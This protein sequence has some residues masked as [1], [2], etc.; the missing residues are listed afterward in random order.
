MSA[1]LGSLKNAVLGNPVTR[2]YNVG[3]QVASFGPGLMWKVYDGK[4]KST[5]QV[6]TSF[7]FT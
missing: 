6:V 7:R 5:G 1:F 3:S 2:E 4:K